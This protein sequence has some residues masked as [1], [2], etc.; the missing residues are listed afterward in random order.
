MPRPTKKTIKKTGLGKADK[1][2]KS[3][4]AYQSSRTSKSIRTVWM[5]AVLLIAVFGIGFLVIQIAGQL[6]PW[7]LAD[8]ISPEQARQQQSLG[9]IVLDVRT[10]EEFVAGHIEGSLFMPLEDLI[11]LKD[12]LPRDKLIITVCRSGVRSIQARYILRDAGFKQVTSMTGGM[13]AWIGLGF[14]VVYGEPVR[15]N[16]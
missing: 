12:A 16:N 5:V 10:R 15:I 13:E 1:A 4:G 7:Q 9:A 3:A 14:P 8:E 6:M 2:G 11:T